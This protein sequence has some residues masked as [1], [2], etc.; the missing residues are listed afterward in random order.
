M[1][2]P[3]Q[4]PSREV[5]TPPRRSTSTPRRRTATPKPNYSS[6]FVLSSIN[7]RTRYS[8]VGLS[9]EDN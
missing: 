4:D 1:P 7:S 5:S 2:R 6:S 8:F 3:T 9:M